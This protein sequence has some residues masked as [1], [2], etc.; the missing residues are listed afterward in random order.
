MGSF[1][2]HSFSFFFFFFPSFFSSVNRQQEEW[3]Q[4]RVSGDLVVRRSVSVL[5]AP[6]IARRCG[7]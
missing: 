5:P 7:V 4:L 6:R 1:F 3:D 2:F